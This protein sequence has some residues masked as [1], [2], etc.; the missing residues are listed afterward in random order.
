[1]KPQ[2]RAHPVIARAAQALAAGRRQEA[3]Q[4]VRARLRDD[5]DDPGAHHLL[6]VI[7]ARD[8]SPR[9]A[10]ALFRRALALAPGFVEAQLSLAQLLV[11]I[12]RTAEALDILAAVLARA[13]THRVALSMQGGLLARERRADAAEQ[14]FRSLT[15]QHPDDGQGWLNYG[16]LLKA[17]GR[18]AEAIAAYQQAIAR[19]ETRGVAWWSR[20][21]VKST[22]LGADDV[23]AMRAALPA[24]RDDVARTHLHFALGK[25]LGDLGEPAAAFEHLRRGNALRLAGSPHNVVDGTATFRANAALFAPAFLAE[26]DGHGASAADP[27]FI[28]GMPR[29]GSTLVEQILASHPLIE[30]TAELHELNRTFRLVG[31]RSAG[32][33]LAGLKAVRLERWREL[34]EHYLDAARRHRVTDRPFFTDKMPSNWLYTG[35]IR[36][37]LP[38]ARIIDV[39][40]H[41]MACGFANFAQHYGRGNNYTYDLVAIGHVYA[42]Y[43]RTMA[44]FD[45]IS[46]GFVHRVHH[47]A[48]I[49][50]LEGEVRRMLAYLNLPFDPACLRFH[51]T[52]RAVHTPST[53]QVR[54]P[55]NR[56]GVDR[57]RAY[58]PWLGPLKE[59]LGPVLDCYPEVPTDGS[60]GGT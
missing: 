59:A 28:V 31:P 40:R 24:A 12:E 34:G 3:E 58:A 51:E 48:L 9:D 41:P 27:I 33:Y 4:V 35:L 11:T 23:A 60:G 30:G 42:D 53:D 43:V 38:N 56:D 36:L 55:I 22:P 52:Q 14:V 16:H 20:A 2:T 29:S 8:G 49:E 54:R 10:E 17:A 5:P 57:W 46:P 37:I 50:D 26:N 32:D 6:G 1:M 19:P 45:A 15:R 47:E 7:A 13:P 25:A 18:T 44:H 39:R 21:N